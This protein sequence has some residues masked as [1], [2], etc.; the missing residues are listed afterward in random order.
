MKFNM[1]DLSEWKICDF[2]F[3]NLLIYLFKKIHFDQS[4]SVVHHLHFASS[5]Q[6]QPQLGLKAIVTFIFSRSY[7]Y[8]TPGTKYIG[9]I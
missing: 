8:Y 1:W 4:L 7:I 9:G 5:M 3:L 6:N 2:Y